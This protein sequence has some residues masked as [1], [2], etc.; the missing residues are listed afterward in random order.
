MFSLPAIKLI[1]FVILKE[2]HC[3]HVS[4]PTTR[5]YKFKKVVLFHICN[6]SLKKFDFICNA[7]NFSPLQAVTH[8]SPPHY[9]V[10]HVLYHIILI[11]LW[12][13]IMKQNYSLQAT[14]H[15]NLL[16]GTRLQLLSTSLT[17]S[18]NIWK[19]F[20]LHHFDQKRQRTS[21]RWTADVAQTSLC[22]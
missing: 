3:Q 13:S 2:V 15:A 9:T 6:T 21:H 19:S 22:V 7:S 12:L 17:V 14:T 18:I 20:L 16:A 11:N 4:N 5:R 8:D 10:D 1:I